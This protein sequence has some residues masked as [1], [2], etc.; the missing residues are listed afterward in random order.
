MKI[1]TRISQN[2]IAKEIGVSQV[3]V[4]NWL[5]M[6]HKPTGLQKKALKTHFPEI[7]QRIEEAWHAR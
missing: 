3:T 7:L 6:R 4:S 5:N 1:K 2:I